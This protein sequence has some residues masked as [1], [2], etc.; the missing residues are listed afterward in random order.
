MDGLPGELGGV[1]GD[2]VLEPCGKTLAEPL[3]GSSDLIG[4]GES[5]SA[6]KLVNGYTGTRPAVKGAELAVTLS[7]E[8][9]PAHI[10]DADDPPALAGV[11]LDDDVFELLRLIEAAGNI[12]RELEGLIRGRRRH[13]HLPCRHLDVLLLDGV[14][15]IAR[16]DAE[17]LERLRVQ[18]YPHAVLTDTENV[19]IAHPREPRQHVPQVDPGVVTEVELV[20]AA[21]R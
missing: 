5:V 10:P 1:E 21:L 15:H 20:V 18:P 3:H 7:P 2:L 4:H 12:H 19:D 16:A 11:D 17:R 14:D 9:H 6:R 8:I 13:P